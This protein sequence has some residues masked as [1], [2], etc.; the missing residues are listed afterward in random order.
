MCADV[1]ANTA[2]LLTQISGR[3]D[4]ASL[5]LSL[6]F[7]LKLVKA[8]S[9]LPGARQLLQ[10]HCLLFPISIQRQALCNFAACPSLDVPATSQQLCCVLSLCKDLSLLAH[11][12]V[13]CPCRRRWLPKSSPDCRCAGRPFR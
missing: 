1:D 7:K 11:I 13:A 4:V 6:P 5:D 9:L 2:R 8:A 12:H 3:M 10:L